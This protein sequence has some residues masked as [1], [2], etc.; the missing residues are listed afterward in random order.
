MLC[1]GAGACAPYAGASSSRGLRATYATSATK[2]A[3]LDTKGAERHTCGTTVSGLRFIQAMKKL[4]RR[5]MLGGGGG[6]LAC[7][8]RVA[9]VGDGWRLQTGES[10]LKVLKLWK[11]QKEEPLVGHGRP[12]F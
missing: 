9:A 6:M 12:F 11:A 3:G 5:V 2:T 4:R 10:N 8:L 1:V 7:E